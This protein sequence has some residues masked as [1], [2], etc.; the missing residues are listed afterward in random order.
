[1]H[2]F[3]WAK[4]HGVSPQALQELTQVFG[5]NDPESISG[6]SEAAIQVRVRLHAS[7]QGA[8]LWR[9]NVGAYQSE[10]G[11]VRYGLCNESKAMN[12]AIKSSDLIGIRPVLIRPEHVGTTIGQFM[13]REVKKGGWHYT[14][15]PRE[16]AQLKFLEIVTALGGDAKFTNGS[17]L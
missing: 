10:A 12:D 11:F 14:G 17:E 4:R 3:A 13:A 6:E 16:V 2:L 7:G 15:T 5:L 9:N 1:M 8:R